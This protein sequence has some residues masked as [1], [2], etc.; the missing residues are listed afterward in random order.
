M[1]WA[2][3]LYCKA[4]GATK[5]L[6]R[7]GFRVH[8]VDRQPQKNYVGERFTQADAIEYAWEHGAE[9]DFI[10]ASP[11]CQA[12]S[13]LRHMPT[14]K[15]HPDMIGATREALRASGVPYCI[16]NVEGAPLGASGYLTMLC[17]TMFGL[18]TRDGR[19]ELRRH[20]IF[21]TTFPMLRP[22]CRHGARRVKLGVYGEGSRDASERYGGHPEPA[23]ITVT[24]NNPNSANTPRV[25]TISVCG[26]GSGRGGQRGRY[27]MSVTGN[28][29]QTNV[30]RNRIRQTFSVRDAREAMGIEWMT[31][32]EL[33]QA[34]PPAY[35]EFIARALLQ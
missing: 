3:D 11:P 29:P 1:K 7:A 12:F 35:S 22:E 25:D 2:L 6:Q 13:V 10:W 31:M 16:E 8:G 24:G 19:A 33:S 23:V 15:E 4:G 14:S 21:E 26:T 5:G 18:E 9:Y 30:A 27:V 34:V 17:G 20:R 28:T 32:A